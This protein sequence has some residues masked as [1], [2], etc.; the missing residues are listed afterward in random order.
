MRFE[1]IR[2]VYEKGLKDPN[3]FFITG[4][5]G[6]MKTE[7]FRRD[8]DGRY[9]NGGMSEQNII[10]M[11]AGLALSGKQAV[12]YSIVPF[13]TLR[14][15]EQIKVDVCDHNA[16]VIVIG[17]GEGFAYGSAGVTHFSIEEVGAFRG[18]PN[19]KI[20]C[21]ADPA[22]T[23]SLMNQV[24]AVGGPAY[25][26]IGRG[27]EASLPPHEVVFGKAAVMRPG[28]DVTIVAYGTIVA[29]ALK[30]AEILE[31]QGV[32]AEVL[33]MHTLKPFDA[34]AI[35]ERA[36]MRKGIFTLEEH[37]IYGALGSAVAETLMESPVR[38]AVFKRFGV[39]DVWPEVVGT[40]DYLRKQF[41]LSG[42]QVAAEIK[43][44]I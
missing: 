21:P 12:V 18:L 42:E 30:A 23:N 34:Q 31:K 35:L 36:G 10:G 6:H 27:K 19:M 11:A 9:F 5:Y 37:N 32:S 20:V 44:V 16:N 14:C 38:P 29:E 7:E 33:N 25:V 24:L 8:F 43:K 3:L 40:Q 26:R 28:T 13:I 4:D 22:E 17:G 2:A 39:P 41:G 15:F 1:A